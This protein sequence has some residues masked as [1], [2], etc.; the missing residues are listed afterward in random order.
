MLRDLLFVQTFLFMFPDRGFSRSNL[1]ILHDLRARGNIF[2]NH[3][4]GPKPVFYQMEREALN[5]T[6][7]HLL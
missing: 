7:R 1:I 5:I 4:S 6:Q 3:V 2:F